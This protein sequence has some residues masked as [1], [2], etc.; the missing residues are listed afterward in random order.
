MPNL[1]NTCLVVSDMKHTDGRTDGRTD[2][3]AKYE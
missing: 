1:I 2:A 3:S